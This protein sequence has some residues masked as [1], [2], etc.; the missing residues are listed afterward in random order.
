MEKRDFLKKIA[1]GLLGVAGLSY[2]W[3]DLNLQA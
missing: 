2:V 1:S 3:P